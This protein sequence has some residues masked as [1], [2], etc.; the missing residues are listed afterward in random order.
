MTVSS[1]AGLGELSPECIDKPRLADMT[2]PVH[3]TGGLYGADGFCSLTIH[4]VR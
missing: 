4:P 2:E 3:A 1:R